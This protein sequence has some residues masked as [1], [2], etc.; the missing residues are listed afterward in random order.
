MRR[1]ILSLQP[2]SNDIDSKPT[3]LIC[4]IFVGCQTKIVLL[5]KPET[6][7][8]IKVTITYVKNDIHVCFYGKTLIQTFLLWLILLHSHENTSLRHFKIFFP[9]FHA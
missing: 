8:K 6:A 5:K 4:D 9:Y 2:S 1:W 7:K 3:D